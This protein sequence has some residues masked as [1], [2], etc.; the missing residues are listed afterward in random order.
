MS[1]IDILGVLLGMSVIAVSASAAAEHRAAC[2][3]AGV[4]V[5]LTKPVSLEALRGIAEQLGVRG[6]SPR[7]AA[8]AEGE[9]DSGPNC[10]AANFARSPLRA[11]RSSSLWPSMCAEHN[12]NAQR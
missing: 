8:Q 2:L 6:A 11:T 7:R 5:F 10:I 12:G 9:F 4:N 1:K 3:Q